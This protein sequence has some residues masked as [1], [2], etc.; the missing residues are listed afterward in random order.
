M[1]SHLKLEDFASPC[2]RRL[3]LTLEGE[4]VR[5]RKSNDSLANN[6]T[7]TAAIRGRIAA[8]NEILAL[9]QQASAGTDAA[10]RTWD[11]HGLV[12][13]GGALQPGG[14]APE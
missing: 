8:V 12:S 7:K 1:Q 9:A 2:W 4:L 13:V 14:D 5:L 3:A 10:P 11:E 6:E